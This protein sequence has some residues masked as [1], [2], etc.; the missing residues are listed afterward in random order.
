MATPRNRTYVVPPPTPEELEKSRLAFDEFLHAIGL[1]IVTWQ[2]VEVGVYLLYKKMCP[3]D[4]DGSC[5]V[6]YHSINGFEIRGAVVD[7]LV[8]KHVTDEAILSRWTTLSQSLKHRKRIRDKFVHWSV[9]RQ[10]GEG[11]FQAC[12]LTPQFTDDRVI[13]SKDWLKPSSGAM[14]LADILGHVD[15]FKELANQLRE[16]TS[17]LPQQSLPKK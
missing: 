14:K 15:R 1:A 12:Y 10:Y 13:E 5:N 16:F 4:K 6:I 2:S 9:I 8:K 11:I 3:P 17:S 7:G